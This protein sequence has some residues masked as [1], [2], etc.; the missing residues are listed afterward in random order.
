MGWK[1]TSRNDWFATH[2]VWILTVSFETKPSIAPVP[3]RMYA[4]CAVGVYV[5]ERSQSKRAW[6]AQ[7]CPVQRVLGTHRLAEPVSKTTA[8][9]CETDVVNQHE[10]A[11]L[12]FYVSNPS[13]TSPSLTL[14]ESINQTRE[15]GPGECI[16]LY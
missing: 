10:R 12:V 16:S 9:R 15:Q 14:S 11:S 4:V 5:V 6:L 8:N 13:F 1:V 3:N 2:T 7:L